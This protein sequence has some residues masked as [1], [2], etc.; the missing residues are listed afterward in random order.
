[1]FHETTRRKLM[2][3]TI[4]KTISFTANN[5]KKV[6]TTGRNFLF[7][8]ITRKPSFTSTQAVSSKYNIIF[9]RVQLYRQLFRREKKKKLLRCAYV[10]EAHAF[11]GEKNQRRALH[12]HRPIVKIQK[13]NRQSTT[14]VPISYRLPSTQSRRKSTILTL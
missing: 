12:C 9:E 6:T 10:F 11:P 14:I 8:A 5:G 3:N 2:Y 1:M 4:P 7:S 13:K